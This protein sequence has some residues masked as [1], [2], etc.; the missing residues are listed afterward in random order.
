M[1]GIQ[2]K[3]DLLCRFMYCSLGNKVKVEHVGFLRAFR[4]RP[5]PLRTINKNKT[6]QKP[7]YPQRL[8]VFACPSTSDLTCTSVIAYK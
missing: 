1:L 8:K 3:I 2:R 5:S 6:K 7:T 4:F